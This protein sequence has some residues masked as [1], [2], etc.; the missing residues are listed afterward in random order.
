M[1][2]FRKKMNQLSLLQGVRND[3]EEP[4]DVAATA[5][6]PRMVDDV[7]GL[8]WPQLCSRCQGKVEQIL[9]DE[10]D[11]G[12]RERL[13]SLAYQLISPVVQ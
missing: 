4:Q 12:L 7:T 10:L 5:S 8:V 11:R 9:N 3:A 6:T 13:S 1:T 2:R